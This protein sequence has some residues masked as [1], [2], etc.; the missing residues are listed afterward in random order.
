[1]KTNCGTSL[2]TGSIKSQLAD[3]SKRISESSDNNNAFKSVNN[4]VNQLEPHME[5]CATDLSI[6]KS[7]A[8]SASLSL[9]PL[10]SNSKPTKHLAGNANS[11]KETETSTE[12]NVAD[13][14]ETA[15]T[16]LAMPCQQSSSA[17]PDQQMSAVHQVKTTVT[18]EA[19]LPVCETVREEP[20][21]ESGKEENKFPVCLKEIEGRLDMDDYKSVVRYTKI[22][23]CRNC[24]HY[25]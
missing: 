19:P 15:I 22:F 17:A 3:E 2:E 25:I 18:T 4:S 21:A 20:L 12:Y 6:S 23:L 16:F 13:D 14:L 11:T 24:D 7:D 10:N 8:D 1:L 5:L 9:T